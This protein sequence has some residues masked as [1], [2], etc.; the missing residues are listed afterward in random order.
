MMKFIIAATLVFFGGVASVNAESGAGQKDIITAELTAANNAQLTQMNNT[1]STVEA[2]ELTKK[3]E[4]KI[5][6]HLDAKIQAKLNSQL[7]FI[8]K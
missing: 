4:D 1:V 5:S 3:L 2:E 8:A 7:M 6:S